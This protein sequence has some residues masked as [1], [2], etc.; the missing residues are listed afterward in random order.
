[1]F[2]YIKNYDVFMFDLNNCIVDVAKYHYQA[3]LI[4]LK[5]IIGNNFDMSYDYFCEKFHPK[6]LKS[7]EHYLTN[8]LHLNNLNDLMITKNINYMNIIRN[9]NV[10][11]INGIEL[12]ITKI[13]EQNKKF[14]IM[15][16][17]FFDNVEYFTKQIKCKLGYAELH[18]PAP[19]FGEGE[20]VSYFHCEKEKL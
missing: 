13:L 17:T 8:T 16:D 14:I 20:T 6:D 11:L 3:W 4:T 2:E 10:K 19:G 18:K 12:F 1:M 5:S 7:L 15:S 9:N